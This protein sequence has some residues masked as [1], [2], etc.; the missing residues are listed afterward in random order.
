MAGGWHG[1]FLSG[2]ACFR[3]L[4]AALREDMSPDALGQ[5]MSAQE[6]DMP[7]ER[8]TCHPKRVHGTLK[9]GHGTHGHSPLSWRVMRASMADLGGWCSK[10]TL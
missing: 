1:R 3:S 4:Q 7:P 10:S 9:G 6:A 5:D 8:R 2:H